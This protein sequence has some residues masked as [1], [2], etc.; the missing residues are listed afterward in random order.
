M[1]S[2]KPNDQVLLIHKAIA[3]TNKF[4]FIYKE[5]LNKNKELYET[6][7]NI[8]MNIGNLSSNYISEF[9]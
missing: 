9:I 5:I 2:N 3:L 6:Y 1:K 8:K 7:E 4:D